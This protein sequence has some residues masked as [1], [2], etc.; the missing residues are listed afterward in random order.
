MKK[1]NV[2]VQTGS[3]HRFKR[4]E[5]LG[6]ANLLNAGHHCRSDFELLYLRDSLRRPEL[7]RE[8]DLHPGQFYPVRN[9]RLARHRQLR[10]RHL[11]LLPR[12]GYF[13][14]YPWNSVRRPDHRPASYPRLCKLY[15]SRVFDRFVLH[16]PKKK[17]IFFF[18]LIYR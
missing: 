14:C 3:I 9:Q 13:P 11:K 15:P 16:K 10:P 5:Q 1:S 7:R 18:I 4:R 12:M 6:I 2:P 8:P 17:K